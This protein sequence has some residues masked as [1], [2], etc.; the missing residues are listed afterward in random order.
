MA[1][2]RIGEEGAPSP[3]VAIT[4]GRARE[5]GAERGAEAPAEARGRARAEEVAGRLETGN[6]AS[7]ERVFVD[8]DRVL[9]LRLP[10]QWLSQ[11]GWIG[12]AAAASRAAP[13]E[14]S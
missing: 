11:A 1:G 9:A 8:D 5:L 7:I 6:A 10:M 2:D 12:R 3:S 4:A 13:F 14:A